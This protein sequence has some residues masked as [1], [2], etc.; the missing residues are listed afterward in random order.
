MRTMDYFSVEKYGYS[1]SMGNG[2]GA[3]ELYWL[4]KNGKFLEID[5]EK[6]K[7]LQIIIQRGV[8][9]IKK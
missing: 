3:I 1:S 2:S 9:M 5:Y 7:D 6:V 4:Y 8:K